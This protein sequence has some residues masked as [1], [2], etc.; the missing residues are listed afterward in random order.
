MSDG[1]DEE[2]RSSAGGAAAAVVDDRSAAKLTHAVTSYLTS[3]AVALLDVDRA[4]VEPVAKRDATIAAVKAFVTD[5]QQTVLLLT[6]TAAVAAAP[7]AAA[8]GA[9]S[10]QP[11]PDG[12]A[13]RP[14]PAS[15]SDA[16]EAAKASFA[17][18]AVTPD[19]AVVAE[20]R[21][22]MA[23]V[24]P[25]AEVVED[26]LALAPEGALDELPPSDPAAPWW[27]PVDI[28]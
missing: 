8:D 23:Q 5:S 12:A 18:R 11:Q 1:G 25:L 19:A 3:S 7:P 20:L 4:E 16:V 28:L 24:R 10:E 2:T 26:G 22:L 14:M 17:R 9:V 13:T 15:L 21:A 6:R 27:D